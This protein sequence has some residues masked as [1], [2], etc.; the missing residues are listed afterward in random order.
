M[1]FLLQKIPKKEKIF[2]E[3]IRKIIYTKPENYSLYRLA[4]K[5]A[6]V[7]KMNSTEF[8]ESNE[9]L[10]Y[11]GDSVLDL[12]V[13]EFLFKKYP[14]K[15]EA[16]LTEIRARIV[17]RESLN[18]L[19]VKM[20]LD[21]MIHYQKDNTRLGKSLYGDA[22]E[23]FIGALYL[24]KGFNFC[25]NFIIHHILYIHYNLEEITQTITNFKSSVLEWAQK[26]NKA[27]SFESVKQ[28]IGENQKQF[29]TRLSFD[30]ELIC[31][32]F[33]NNKKKSEQDASRRAYKKII[34][35]NEVNHTINH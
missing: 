13:A 9:R 19:A 24:D 3:A 29:R 11:L 10:E 20:G 26:N 35:N 4:L 15:S 33:G 5:H 12:I 1:F 23:A 32:G 17:N 30:G 31:E 8:L 27:L 18:D 16:F 14:Y 7:A 25:R 2:I 22:V 34:T 6:S 28:N 21:K